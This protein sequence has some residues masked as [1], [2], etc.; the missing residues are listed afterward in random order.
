MP[1]MAPS[2]PQQPLHLNLNQKAAMLLPTGW[3]GPCWG[4]SSALSCR[5]QHALT[6]SKQSYSA[7]TEQVLVFT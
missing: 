6:R 1:F 5:Q 3:K 4:L 2:Q 7:R